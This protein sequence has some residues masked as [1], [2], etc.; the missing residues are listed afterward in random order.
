MYPFGG[1]PPFIP[2]LRWCIVH[3][4]I[5]QHPC[6]LHPSDENE[7]SWALW[8]AYLKTEFI[9]LRFRENKQW[10]SSTGVCRKQK[11]IKRTSFKYDF[12]SEF[13]A[14]FMPKLLQPCG[15]LQTFTE[16]TAEAVLAGIVASV[17]CPGPSHSIVAV[18]TPL[19]SS[20]SSFAVNQSLLSGYHRLHVFTNHIYRNISPL[21]SIG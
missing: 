12:F 15:Y 13:F 2:L 1:L 3:T 4:S 19:G 9:S 5:A 16:S 7:C 14:L 10:K 11:N 6:P 17:S 18:E 8:T 20:K 21:N